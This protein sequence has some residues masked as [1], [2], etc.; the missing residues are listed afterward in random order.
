MKIET[1]LSDAHYQAIGVTAQAISEALKALPVNASTVREG[2][3]KS[4]HR[5][6]IMLGI[7]ENTEADE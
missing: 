4:M 2:L 6:V 1:P 5:L 3:T 7:V